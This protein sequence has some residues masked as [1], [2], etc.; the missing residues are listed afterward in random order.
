[1]PKSLKSRGWVCIA[2]VIL[3]AAGCSDAQKQQWNEFWGVGGTKRAARTTPKPAAAQPRKASADQPAKKSST[4]STA[5]PATEDQQAGQVSQDVSTYSAGMNPKPKETTYQPNDHNSK[6]QRQHDPERQ[7]RI[8]EA[9]AKDQE[10]EAIADNSGGAMERYERNADGN[11]TD[12]PTAEGHEG[13]SVVRTATH[14]NNDAPQTSRDEIEPADTI[15]PKPAPEAESRDGSNV[16]REKTDVADG[17][18]KRDA[19]SAKPTVESQEH[20]DTAQGDGPTVQANS[21]PTASTGEPSA[22][23]KSNGDSTHEV[24]ELVDVSVS[25]APEPQPEVA[26]A[27]PAEP[28]MSANAGG[29]TAAA[30][31]SF[32]SRIAEQEKLV[33]GDPNNLEE[34]Y[35]LRLMYLID[36]QDEKAKDEIAGVDADL[37]QIITAQVESLISARSTS[38]RDPATWATRQLESIEELRRLI[39]ERADLVV[40]KVALCTAVDGFGRYKPIEPAEFKAGKKN[41]VVIYIE[42]DNFSCKKLNSGMYRTLLSARQ[43]LLTRDG[44]EIWVQKADNIEDLARRPRRDFYLCTQPI[45]IPKTLPPGDYVLKAEVEDVLAGKINSGVANFTIV[46]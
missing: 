40:S 7:K 35:R 21:N 34:Q 18:T 8:R 5:D 39:K 42:V 24:P 16:T 11:N 1:M 22:A 46:P 29:T 44:K 30:E 2:A 37:Q 14:R 23:E 3:A 43:T 25:A 36:G 32:A 20:D 28:V 33:A 15:P 41:R 31:P 38:G 9:A 4:A 27:E 17:K 6:I 12:A 26:T 45:A 19:A 10:G 13:G